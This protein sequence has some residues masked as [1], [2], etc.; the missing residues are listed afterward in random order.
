MFQRQIL[1][2]IYTHVF[3]RNI[4][5]CHLTCLRIHA[6]NLSCNITC[7]KQCKD[8]GSGLF[9]RTLCLFCDKILTRRI[10]IISLLYELICVYDIYYTAFQLLVQRI[11]RKF[12]S[13]NLQT[14]KFIIIYKLNLLT[15]PACKLLLHYL[16][17]CKEVI[18]Q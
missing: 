6:P 10:L 8:L 17:K 18:F 7:D 13:R 9:Q 14:Y 1:Q 15:S 5:W 11:I 16:G 12:D 4:V 2:I 3:M